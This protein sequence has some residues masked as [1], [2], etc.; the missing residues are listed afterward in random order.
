[1]LQNGEKKF[2]V[3]CLINNFSCD[4][5]Y[6]FVEIYQFPFT[7][8]WKNYLD[9]SNSFFKIK[10]YTNKNQMFANPEHCPYRIPK[11]SGNIPQDQP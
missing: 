3:F 6:F 1:M 8:V 7:F 9:H 4:P 5:Y 2:C 10:Y 11:T